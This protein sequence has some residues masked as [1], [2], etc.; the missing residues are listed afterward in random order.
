MRSRDDPIRPASHQS[1][2]R[3]LS[4]TGCCAFEQRRFQR[5]RGN[6]ALSAT[7]RDSVS[8]R[9]HLERHDGN[10][11]TS[12]FNTCIWPKINPW[13]SL[14]VIRLFSLCGLV[15]QASR[16]VGTKR[17]WR[18]LAGRPQAPFPKRNFR[19][20]SRDDPNR[21]SRGFFLPGQVEL[22]EGKEPANDH[23]LNDDHTF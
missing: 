11:N 18:K 6:G 13:I 19:C 2:C 1:K 5:G 17:G 4:P 14:M 12:D 9:R 10:W 3:V 7:M 22:Q 21:Q 15:V 8:R 16:R 23:K 20:G